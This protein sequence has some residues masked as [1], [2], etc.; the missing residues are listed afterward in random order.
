MIVM[1]THGLTGVR[2][3]VLGSVA[4]RVLEH[5]AVPVVLVHE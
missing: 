3:A 1:A 5:A 2:R 4:G